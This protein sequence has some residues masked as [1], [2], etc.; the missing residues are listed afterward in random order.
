MKRIQR[1]LMGLLKVV[2]VISLCSMSL[3]TVVDA[4]GRY[5]FNAPLTGSVELIELLMIMVIFASIPIVTH[6][7]THVKV[8]VFTLFKSP[9]AQ[10]V[11]GRLIH[12]LS[13][14]I[15]GL[16]AYATLLK[17]QSVVDYG[18]MT[19]MLSI[20][21]APFVFVMVI[22]LTF[23][24]LLHLFHAVGPWDEPS[25]SVQYDDADPSTGNIA[26]AASALPQR[27]SHD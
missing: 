16:L 17:A 26:H 23:N 19:Q 3:V 2:V 27:G 6:T 1:W 20:S 22:L 4:V 5:F 12:A 24:G 10:R 21:L 8:D 25:G 14:G 11:Q 15:S 18:D 7:Q 9:A 13:A